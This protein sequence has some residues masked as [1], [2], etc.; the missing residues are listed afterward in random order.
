MK[1]SQKNVAQKTVFNWRLPVGTVTCLFAMSASALLAQ[2]T[3]RFTFDVGAGF[4]QTTG[5]TGR[6]LDTG[7]NAGAGAG[8]NFNRY[9]GLMVDAKFNQ[10]GVNSRTL[11]SIGVPGGYMRIFSATLDPVFHVGAYRRADMYI[12]GGGGLYR[13]TQEFTQPSISTFTTFDPFFGFYNVSVPSTQILSSY[14][15][16]KPGVNIGAGFAVGTKWR[17]KLFGE[18][19][20]NRIFRGNNRHLDYI[21]VSFG[22]RW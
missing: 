11:N 20:Y 3:P 17:G 21:P 15:V 7:W 6:R 22:F 4:S 8:V 18:A 9:V 19:R 10:L 14:T 12:I 5:G 1:N 2:E 13:T 16:N